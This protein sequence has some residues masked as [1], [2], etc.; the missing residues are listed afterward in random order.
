MYIRKYVL[1]QNLHVMVETAS[2]ATGK[3]NLIDTV[4]MQR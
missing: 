2:L 3:L 1:S 4:Y